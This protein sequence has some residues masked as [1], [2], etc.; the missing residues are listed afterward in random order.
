MVA[1][2]GL[3]RVRPFTW[4]PP[5]LPRSRFMPE[6]FLADF[7]GQRSLSDW[8]RCGRRPL[9]SAAH[10]SRSPAPCGALDRIRPLLARSDGTPARLGPKTCPDG[11]AN[12]NEACPQADRLCLR[13]LSPAP[14]QARRQLLGNRP[15]SPPAIGDPAATAWR[16]ATSSL[17]RCSACRPRWSAPCVAEPARV[18]ARPRSRSSPGPTASSARQGPTVGFWPLGQTLLV[19]GHG[20]HL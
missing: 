19:A 20:P 1:R 15:A 5:S 3:A 7:E 8:Q 4:L 13:R 10:V 18:A 16:C 14:R 9:T 12:G 17:F 6:E 2:G 11:T